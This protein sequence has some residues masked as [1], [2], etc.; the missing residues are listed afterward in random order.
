V[1]TSGI[2]AELRQRRP[3]RHSI[4]LGP[5]LDGCLLCHT[6]F[7]GSHSATDRAHGT[8]KK[9]LPELSQLRS[10]GCEGLRALPQRH[11]VTRLPRP[12]LLLL[13]CLF[14]PSC[15]RQSHAPALIQPLIDPTKLATL[16]D[17][18]ANQRIQKITAILFEAKAGGH[19]PGAV[20]GKAVELIDWGGTEKGRLTA[21]AM[22][23]NLTIMERLG[24]TTP[25]DLAEMKRG[26]A[27][28]VRIGPY[29]GEVVSVDHIIPRS[30]EP[31]LDNVIANLELMP[32]SVNQRKGDKI[33]DR[34]VSMARDFHA[35]GLLSDKGF[36]TVLAAKR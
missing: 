18:G 30:V 9:D 7:F 29:A 31:E 36:A 6:L 15:G 20:A 35:A 1:P 32:L 19:D 23:R 2:R 33:G 28:T 27:A 3:E 13:F 5:F 14:V 34:Q 10:Q 25:A 26:R 22:V 17:R 4:F 16:G 8:A 24:S 12:L 21:A 11:Q